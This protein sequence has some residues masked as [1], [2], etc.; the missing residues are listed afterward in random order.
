MPKNFTRA[1]LVSLALCASPAGADEILDF[2]GTIVKFG[3]GLMQVKQIDTQAVWN[4]SLVNNYPR[5]YSN[6]HFRSKHDFNWGE[7]VHVVGH[8][9]GTDGILADLLEP[10]GHEAGNTLALAAPM[11]GSF[12]PTNFNVR[13]SGECF[14]HV[15]VRVEPQGSGA[16]P[17]WTVRGVADELGHFD[18]PIESGSAANSP[19]KLTISATGKYYETR[20]Q[21]VQVVRTLPMPEPQPIAPALPNTPPDAGRP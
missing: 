19:L 21:V 8:K 13:G 9:S 20:L 7:Q 11:E 6:G 18:I 16:A 12:E 5:G 17:A 10:P 15:T 1:L 3:P 14:A 2:Y 4:I